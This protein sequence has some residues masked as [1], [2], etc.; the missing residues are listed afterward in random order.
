MDAETLWRIPRVGAPAAAGGRLVVPVTRYPDPDSKGVTRLWQVEAGGDAKPLTCPD[1]DSTRPALDPTGTRLAFLRRVDGTR[2]V[3]VMRLDGGEAVPVTDLPWGVHGHAWLPDGSGLVVLADTHPDFQD[4]QEAKEVVE[5]QPDVHVTEDAVFRYWDT[6]LTGGRV[7]HLFRCDLDGT[8]RDLMPGWRRWMRWPI[9]RDPMADV[10]I[11]PDGTR[12]LFCAD[13]SPPPHRDIRW[14]LF[15]VDMEGGEP[16]DLTPDIPGH[17][18]RPRFLSATDVLYGRQDV[19]DYYADLVRLVVFDGR[20]HRL[21]LEWDSSPEEWEVTDSG[22]VFVAEDRGRRHLWEWS[23]GEEPAVLARGGSFAHPAPL[24]DGRTAAVH[25]TLSS[26]PEVVVVSRGGRSHVTSFTTDTMEG[27]PLGRV[28]EMVFSGGRGDPVHAWL[29]H[30]PAEAS[31]PPLVHMIHGGPHSASLDGWHWRWNPQ[32][33]ASDGYLV[34]QVNFHGSTSFGA[35]FAESIHGAWGDLPAIDVEAATDRL[36]EDGRVDP[37]RMAITGGSYGGYL[38]AW[39]TTRTD[40]YACAVAHAPVVDLPGMYATDVTMG[41]RRNYGAEL[42]EDPDRVLAWSPNVHFGAVST[43]TLVV[44]GEK[45]YRV[46]ASQGLELYGLLKAK[47]VPARLV[48]YPDENHWVLTPR[49]SLHWHSE[50]LGWLRRWLGG[51]SYARFGD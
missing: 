37:D 49:N 38:V 32:V 27:V 30:P 24:G 50:V 25:S 4:P 48:Y 11:S 43:P 41:R 42:F 29:I 23:P 33:F 39:L 44:H 28:E 20:E 6:W 16:V 1:S 34:C 47:G 9:V 18:L 35:G 15:Q 8:L 7:P 10:A 21:A 36:V 2:Q 5:S 31:K 51:S 19:P 17:A 12:L 26:P 3:H 14:H 46:P 13:V 22:T 40:R 45:D